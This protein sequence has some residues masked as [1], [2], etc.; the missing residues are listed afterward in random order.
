MDCGAGPGGSATILL[1]QN[2][3]VRFSGWSRM[4]GNGLA[5]SNPAGYHSAQDC[6]GSEHRHC[7]SSN[8]SIFMHG[9]TFSVAI[10]PGMCA[11][12]PGRLHLSLRIA[13]GRICRNRPRTR[14]TSACLVLEDTPRFIERRREIA[15]WDQQVNP[16]RGI[17]RPRIQYVVGPFCLVIHFVDPMLM[18]QFQSPNVVL[19]HDPCP[20]GPAG[21]IMQFCPAGYS[22]TG[23]HDHLVP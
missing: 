4:P 13:P 12:F 21:H 15:L 6:A 2:I 23:P 5:S 11:W 16:E 17:N 22:G 8:R 7:D 9:S 1:N 14:C 3:G 20:P 18:E 19:Q 10:S